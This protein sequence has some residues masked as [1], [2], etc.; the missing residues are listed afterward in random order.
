[1]AVRLDTLVKDVLPCY[2]LDEDGLYSTLRRVPIKE[3]GTVEVVS[4]RYEVRKIQWSW[5]EAVDIKT[6]DVLRD[7][8]GFDPKMVRKV[9]EGKQKSH[10]GYYFRHNNIYKERLNN[11]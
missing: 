8:E 10:K 2:F 4:K 6:G 9:L 1:M 3:D 11:V 5:V 7:L